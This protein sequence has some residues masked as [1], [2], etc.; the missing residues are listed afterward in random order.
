MKIHIIHLWN[1]ALARS[2]LELS[3]ERIPQ[4]QTS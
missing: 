3:R 1:K 2:D 4:V